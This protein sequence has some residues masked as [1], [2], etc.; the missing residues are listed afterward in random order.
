LISVHL[1]L[2]PGMDGT[3]RLFAR[4]QAAVRADFSFIVASYSAE[5]PLDYDALSD[6]VSLPN[7]PFALIAESFSGPIGIRLA[8]RGSPYLRALILV[9]SFAKCP[10]RAPKFF[11]GLIAPS[12]MPIASAPTVLRAMLLDHDASDDLVNAVRATLR[13]VSADVLGFRLRAILAED[14]SSTFASIRV[15]MM[16]LRA[17]RDRLVP[18]RVARELAR[19]RPD[20]EIVDIDAPHLVLQSQ[21]ERAATLITDFLRRLG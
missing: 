9:A 2:L 19:V 13:S 3:G 16:Y 10:I 6:N 8:A 7:E 18:A 17:R 14:R 1:V 5:A 4:F 21:P 20:L 11:G 12:L 15:P